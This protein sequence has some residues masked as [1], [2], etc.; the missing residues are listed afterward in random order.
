MLEVGEGEDEDDRPPA[1]NRSPRIENYVAFLGVAYGVMGVYVQ[2]KGP[3]VYTLRAS[4]PRIKRFH[5]RVIVDYADVQGL[6]YS[7]GMLAKCFGEGTVYA[8]LK[9][10]RESRR[11]PQGLGVVV[12]KGV[13]NPTGVTKEI[14]DG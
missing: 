7:Q 12:L 8:E 6:A 3:G 4:G 2:N 11:S 13:P 1:T 5:D 14:E 9:R 10:G